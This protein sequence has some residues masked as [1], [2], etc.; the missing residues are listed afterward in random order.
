M[1]EPRTWRRSR[2][3]FTLIELLVV[4]AIIAILIGL[5]LP[6][7]QKVREAAARM[8]CQNNLKQIG[9]ALHSY[10]DA[11]G[12]L[13]DYG[14]DFQAQPNPPFGA[15]GHSALSLILPYL[16]QGNV[17]RLARF[18]RALADPVNLPPN[19][20]SDPAA[21]AVINVYRCPS[22]PNRTVDYSPYFVSI[23]FPNQGPMTLG[24]TDYAVVKGISGNFA[25]QCCPAGTASGHTG[26]MGTKGIY[27]SGPIG[28]HKIT[29]ITDGTS[30]TILVA[31]DAG[32]QQVYAQGRA[33]T[34]NNPGQVGW[35]LNGAWADY[36]TAIT[37]SGF[38]AAG[39]V[40]NG[41]RCV[42]NCN[43]VNQIYAFHTG[44]ANALRADGSVF[45][46][47]DSIAPGVL[48]ALISYNGGEV[49]GDY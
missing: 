29:D 5:L 32:R 31:E 34:P 17:A 25:S 18:D 38:N 30:S 15:Q 35:T 16:E 36:N 6:A 33:V 45:L 39:T 26:V 1:I 48:A 2:G 24:P 9:L 7:V 8:S 42:V 37:V 22:S 28:T 20:G 27:Q 44:G 10:N 46:M 14:F 13:P 40:L 41:G 43:N 11:T 19:Y 3:A 12:T 49:V 21:A 23:G 4:I 47:K